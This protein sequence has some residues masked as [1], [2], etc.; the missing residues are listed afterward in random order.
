M[1]FGP[2]ANP[3]WIQCH[4][5]LIEIVRHRSSSDFLFIF[6]AIMMGVG[7]ADYIRHIGTLFW[8]FSPSVR[9]TI[10]G[11]SFPACISNLCGAQSSWFCDAQF[12]EPFDASTTSATFAHEP[13]LLRSFQIRFGFVA[14]S[15]LVL[16]SLGFKSWR[17]NLSS[18]MQTETLNLR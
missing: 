5:I 7:T 18:G 6:N 13:R 3:F 4:N 16:I 12:L 14:L 1:Y 11:R 15:G 10:F 17:A 8:T 2:R 9:G